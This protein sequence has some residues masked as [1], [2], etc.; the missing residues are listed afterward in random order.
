M[1][2]FTHGPRKGWVLSDYD[3]ALHYRDSRET[4]IFC[5]RRHELSLRLP[6][7]ARSLGTQP[8]YHT[9]H[10]NYFLIEL[11]G[12]D[13]KKLEYE[14]YFQVNCMQKGLL[15]LFIRS[16]FVRDEDRRQAQPKKR[17]ISFFVIAHNTQIGKLIK[18]QK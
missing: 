11:V 5:F 1:H 17:K 9:G 2:C 13:G 15:K 3:P 12:K 8:C 18:M 16:A 14:V 6:D 7:I 4:R 10:G